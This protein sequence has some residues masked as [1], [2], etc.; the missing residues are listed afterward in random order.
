MEEH[1]INV[2]LAMPQYDNDDLLEGMR[3]DFLSAGLTVERLDLR[4]S[5]A[6]VKQ[7][8]E[9][10]PDTNVV[11][12]SQHQT[13]DSYS[14]EE[15][16]E[17]SMKIDHMCLIPIIDEDSD[18]YVRK[19]EARGI[20]TALYG[21]DSDFENVAKLIRFGRTKREART[22]Y[23]IDS[24]AAHTTLS[25][26][27]DSKN[28][29]RYLA[30]C[31]Q[32]YEELA[33]RLALL[34][35]RLNSSTK[36]MEV[37]GQL[38]REIFNLA[39][40]MDSYRE[41]CRL[42]DEERGRRTLQEAHES[43][44]QHMQP[45]RTKK[46]TGGRRQSKQPPPAEHSQ[47]VDIGFVS[48]N[49]GVGCTYSAVMLAHTLAVQHQSRVAIVE[50]D[51]GDDHFENLCR[52]TVGDM[53]VS[54]LTKFTIR[55]VDY[56]FHVPYSR[57]VTQMK[58][59]YDYVVYDFGCTDDDTI[60]EYF[61]CLNHKFVV[62]GSADWRLGELSEFVQALAR[63]DINN[64]FIYMVSLASTRDMGNFSCIVPGNQVVPVP[65]EA[66]PYKP[67]H[68]SR[69]LLDS[70]IQNTRKKKDW[71]QEVGIEVKAARRPPGRK[72]GTAML[73]GITI[74]FMLLA[75]GASVEL[76]HS[77]YRP[78]I[79][80]V[81]DEVTAA[82]QDLKSEKNLTDELKRELE[83]LSVTAYTLKQPVDSGT[84]ITRS[85]VE[86]VTIK[87]SLPSDYVVE[88]ELGNIAAKVDL[89][90]GVP[91]YKEIVMAPVPAGEEDLQTEESEQTE[92]QEEV[93]GE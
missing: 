15:L 60:R 42:I 29:V 33:T 51:D 52:V 37:L 24:S 32:D 38:P 49:I 90:P 79:Q 82:G 41:L 27:Y 20:Y 13:T 10:Y 6:L 4:S 68:A 9:M 45:V 2:L 39:A 91:L 85:M 65:Y 1:G 26:G 70:L 11:I 40:R 16:D 18:A 35:G 34:S 62:T 81:S 21:K 31:G 55:D 8:L 57:F 7:Y 30:A 66:N 78:I 14:P 50:F 61:I 88:A 53:N 63:D 83:G 74:L 17:L 3:R 75:A 58:P 73:V 89:Q 92:A 48:T 36:M 23:G 59:C 76:S 19:L 12:V 84:T 43:D 25:E 69:K 86:A 87:T 22:Y 54:G 77:Y 46:K 93:K 64:S 28:A 47:T 67:S 71:G 5:K 56:F 44:V 72:Y 80:K